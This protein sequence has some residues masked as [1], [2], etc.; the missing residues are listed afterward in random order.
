MAVLVKPHQRKETELKKV[1]IINGFNSGKDT[2]VK[3]ISEYMEVANYSY[4]DFTR[5]MLKSYGIDTSKKTDTDRILLAEVNKA[6]EKWGDKP[7]KDICEITSDFINNNIEADILFIHIRS[8]RVIER[9]L[10]DFFENEE[11][12]KKKVSVSTL[13]VSRNIDHTAPTEEDQNVEYY[14]YDYAI[15]NDGS[16]EDLHESAEKY[17]E[18]LKEVEKCT[19]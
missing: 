16:L 15:Y 10:T 17:V 5:E 14:S 2:F 12:K 13:F 9:F 3:Y 1:V 19:Y 8:P 7:Y 11:Y 4:V 18:F 6:L